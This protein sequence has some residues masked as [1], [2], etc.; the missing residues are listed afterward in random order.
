LEVNK[1][2]YKILKY[3]ELLLEIL[4]QIV[5]QQLL[6]HV[7]FIRVHQNEMLKT[8]PALGSSL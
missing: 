2:L 5:C 8:N 7:C 1:T 3:H 4:G 6:W